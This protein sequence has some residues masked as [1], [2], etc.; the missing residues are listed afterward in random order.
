MLRS[1]HSR[2]LTHMMK[3]DENIRERMKT[4]KYKEQFSLEEKL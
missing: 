1:R 3:I 2:T 4:E